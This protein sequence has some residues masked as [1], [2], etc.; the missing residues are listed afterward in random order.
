MQPLHREVRRLLQGLRHPH[1]ADHE[2]LA[3]L[4]QSALETASARE[5]ILGLVDRALASHQPHF[6]AIIQQHDI[7]DVP[8]AQ[9]A[10]HLFLSVR[11][12]HRHHTA[13]LDA[14]AAELKRV[15]HAPEATLGKADANLTAAALCARGWF[16]W[17]SRTRSGLNAAMSAFE[18]ALRADPDYAPAYVGIAE[19]YICSAQYLLSAPEPAFTRAA[20]ALERALC[21]SPASA[22]AHA[23]LG[24]LQ[25]FAR[26]DWRRSRRS[27]QRSLLLNEAHANAHLHVAWHGFLCQRFEEAGHHVAT[28]LALDPASVSSQMILGTYYLFHHELDKAAEQFRFV[29]S[30]DPQN[31]LARYRLGLVYAF[32]GQVRSALAEF[33]AARAEYEQQSIAHIGY[34]QA[35]LGSAVEAYKAIAE[36]ETV[37][38][39]HYVSPLMFA[40]VY[41]GLRDVEQT[42]QAL[43]RCVAGNDIW[44]LFIPGSREFDFLAGNPRFAALSKEVGTAA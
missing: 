16:F 21:L 17:G 3:R 4:L 7:N 20:T 37:A 38:V 14:I 18:G 42:L 41:A 25:L 34:C 13:A 28:L 5:A 32:H 10:R 44:T 27:L 29:L 26:R 12:F 15:V 39:Q 30:V 43:E 36:L 23:A 24:D 19:S 40:F 6:R 33:Q 22:E 31:A 35:L 11:Q 8:A 9:V 2:P 1:L